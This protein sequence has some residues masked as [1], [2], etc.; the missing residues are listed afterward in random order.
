MCEN[1]ESRVTSESEQ[2]LIE[3][4]KKLKY[5]NL[6][7]K[8]EE[9]LQKQKSADRNKQGGA[10]TESGGG[11]GEEVIKYAQ[12]VVLSQKLQVKPLIGPSKSCS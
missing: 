7:F 8:L 9:V 6:N 4:K 1:G 2:N 5:V 3:E 12:E 10:N 11:W